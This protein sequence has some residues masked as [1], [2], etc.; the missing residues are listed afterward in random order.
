MSYYVA[1]PIAV[2][3]SWC[4][5]LPVCCCEGDQFFRA[6]LHQFVQREAAKALR[7]MCVW[8]GNLELSGDR[9]E[10]IES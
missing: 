1:L 5:C 10:L 6:I 3:L 7:G 4:Q 9:I 2:L 8:L